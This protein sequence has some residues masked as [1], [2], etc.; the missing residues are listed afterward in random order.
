MLATTVALYPCTSGI[1][2]AMGLNSITTGPRS[3]WFDSAGELVIKSEPFDV[4]KWLNDVWS[5]VAKAAH[6]RLPFH[7]LE[8]AV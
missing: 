4:R 5:G 7:S 8:V 6:E 2:T 3:Q 1:P